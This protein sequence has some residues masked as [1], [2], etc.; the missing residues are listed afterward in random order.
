MAKYLGTDGKKHNIVLTDK[1]WELHDTDYDLIA[2]IDCEM[3][4]EE[5]FTY[6][7]DL[8]DEDIPNGGY[9]E[10]KYDYKT[11]DVLG[12]NPIFVQ[13]DYCKFFDDEE[14]F[15][16]TNPKEEKMF[17]ELLTEWLGDKHSAEMQKVMTDYHNAVDEELE[18]FVHD[19]LDNREVLP[20]TVGF[21]NEKMS[22]DIKRLTGLE[23]L[24]NRIVI[25][26]D[27]LRHIIKRHGAKG[28]ADHSMQDVK[29]IARLCY[30][31]AN[32]DSIEWDGGVSSH[33]KT[34]KGEKSPQIIIKKKING[35][36]YVIEVVSDSSKKRNIVS[37]AYLT[38]A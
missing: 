13:A 32:Y 25:T 10:L 4:L 3:P 1:K 20:I 23:T 30:V 5:L 15:I 24:G 35:T 19:V 28:K 22:N 14:C 8:L 16:E 29:D 9:I 17:Q 31:L 36:Y 26:A 34:K 12:L 27:D 37:T 38:K 6:D 33:Y 11:N 18:R 7:K 2:R 21:V